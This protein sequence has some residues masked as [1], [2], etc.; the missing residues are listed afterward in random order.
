MAT[1]LMPTY[2]DIKHELHRR[3]FYDF[4]IDLWKELEAEQPLSDNW[5]VKYLCDEM[6]KIGERVFAREPMTENLIVNISPGE[7]KSSITTVFFPVW[8]WTIDP[9]LRIITASYGKELALGHAQKSR[10]LI[11]SDGFQRLYSDKF[12]LRRDMDAKSHYGND[13]GGQRITASVGSAVT[14]KHAHIIIVDDPMNQVDAKSEVKRDE[15]GYWMRKSLSSRKVDQKLTPTILIMQ[16]LHEEDPT[17]VMEE[18]WGRT[19]QLNHIKLPADDRYEI[20]PKELEQYYT[21]D[22]DR[23]VMNPLRKDTDT[24]NKMEDE[25]TVSDAAGQLGQSPKPADGNTLKS[26]WFSQRFSLHDH[27]DLTWHSTFDGAYTKKKVNSASAA[28]IWATKGGK[29]YLRAW[30]TWWLE[31]PEVCEEYPAFLNTYGVNLRGLNYVE[32]KAIG[33]TLVQTLRRVGGINLVEDQPPVGI[34]QQQGK[35]LRADNITPYLRGMNLYLCEGEDWQPFIDQ[36]KVFPNGSHDDLVDCLC[37]I[38]EKV[39]TPNNWDLGKW[40]RKKRQK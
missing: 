29:T 27:P 31:F 34:T 28:I 26:A 8:C 36:C 17:A 7:T 35:E 3:S 25:L 6:Q 12:A 15:A 33:K 30:R 22:T 18:V 9:S 40:K 1:K 11:K 14:G 21:F 24:I 39:I 20:K 38:C 32:P 16:R 19:G 5:H 4:F 2:D 10:D 37:M 23:K 13:R